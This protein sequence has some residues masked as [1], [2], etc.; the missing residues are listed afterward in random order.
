MRL[1]EVVQ[2]FA[3]AEAAGPC[4]DDTTRWKAQVTRGGTGAATGDAETASRLLDG[5][6]G[7]LRDRG[8]LLASGWA[9]VCTFQ[10]ALGGDPA[11]LDYACLD[12]AQA[13][14]RSIGAIIELLFV[15]SLYAYAALQRGE[16]ETARALI[17]DAIDLAKQHGAYDTLGGGL[18][19]ELGFVDITEGDMDGAR[20]RFAHAA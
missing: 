5:K 8:E 3:R 2:W 1:R 6:A 19:A 17:V 11:A 15:Q 18:V 13:D 16:H 9:D 20:E 7:R 4:T 14:F 10:A 12:R